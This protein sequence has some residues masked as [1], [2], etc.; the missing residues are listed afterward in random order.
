[1]TEPEKIESIRKKL[2][3]IISE[4][5]VIEKADSAPTHIYNS[6]D[7]EFYSFSSPFLKRLEGLILKDTP[8]ICINKE[9]GKI[10]F[11]NM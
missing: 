2:C 9:T 1:M 5:L 4:E 11:V 6:D 7:C 3:N 8:Y 10:S